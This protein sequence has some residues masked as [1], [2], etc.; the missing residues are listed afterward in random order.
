MQQ[1]LDNAIASIDERINSIQAKKTDN[2]ALMQA[3]GIG[4]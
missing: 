4:A 3:Q 2:T 1:A